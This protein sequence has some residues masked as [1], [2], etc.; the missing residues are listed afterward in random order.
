MY[1]QEDIEIINKNLSTISREAAKIYLDN[2]EEPSTREYLEVMKEIKEY[3][4]KNDLIIYGGYAQNALIG[5]KNRDD[6]FYDELSRADLEIYSP[7]PI[8]HSMELTDM[9]HK[10]GYKHVEC[11]EGVHNETYKLFVNFLNFSDISY[12]DNHVFKN[13]P[14]IKVEGLK[15]THPHFMLTDAYRVYADPM[16][17]YFRLDKTFSRF[18]T[19]MKYYPFDSKAKFNKLTYKRSKDIDFVLRFIRKHIIHD[20]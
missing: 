7:D 20:F 9:L 19:L 4:K 1:R 3:I 11:K 15:M 5:A 6:E 17:S 16:T 2:Y 13:C 18:S 10:K 12:M 14:T 8:R